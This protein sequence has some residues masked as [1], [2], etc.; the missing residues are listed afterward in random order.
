MA[1][2][3]VVFD[4]DER[5][6]ADTT[7]TFQDFSSGAEPN[8]SGR[9]SPNTASLYDPDVAIQRQVGAGGGMLS[10]DFYAKYFDVDTKLVRIVLTL[11]S[12]RADVYCTVAGTGEV[13][14]DSAT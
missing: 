10:V 9:L 8:A 3:A 7:L 11:S 12:T 4:A 5:V 1:Y 14:E 13:M 2:N 6:P